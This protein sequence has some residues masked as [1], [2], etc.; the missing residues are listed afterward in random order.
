MGLTIEICFIN[1]IY[2]NLLLRNLSHMIVYNKTLF[3]L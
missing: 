1:I 3:L 2:Y